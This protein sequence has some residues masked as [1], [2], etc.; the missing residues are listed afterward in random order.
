[1]EWVLDASFALAWVLPDEASP[2]AER[3]LRDLDPTTVLRVPALWW[4][5]VL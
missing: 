1:M 2:R 4:H 3:F 5:E